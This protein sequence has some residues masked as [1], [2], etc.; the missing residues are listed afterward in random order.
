VKHPV[1]GVVVREVDHGMVVQ[2]DNSA[3]LR[4]GDVEDV[5]KDALPFVQ[6]G[7]FLL[8][9]EVRGGDVTAGH[10]VGENLGE[11][12]DVGQQ[13]LKGTGREALKGVVVRGKEG[14]GARARQ[15]SD[16][17]GGSDS[18]DQGAVLGDKGQALNQVEGGK[19][20]SGGAN[21][22]L[23]SACLRGLK[24]SKEPSAHFALGWHK[25]P[26][27]DVVHAIGP[28][29]VCVSDAGELIEDHLHC[30]TARP[31]VNLHGDVL[32][33][34]GGNLLAIL[35]LGGRHVSRHHV[36]RQNFV[37]ESDILQQIGKNSWWQAVKGVVIT[38]GGRRGGGG[39]GKVCGAVEN[40][41]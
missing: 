33:V 32:L 26:V 9:L 12:G 27:N 22:G 13:L 18:S 6:G 25:Y 15:G 14:E 40:K 38:V 1:S 37:Q 23:F 16:Q 30:A 7:D 11:C 34:K 21:E 8:V 24:H 2:G 28:I 41:P 17:L 29:V 10:V 3:G 31:W 5:N 36:V 4:A 19:L 20:N 35:E 39:E